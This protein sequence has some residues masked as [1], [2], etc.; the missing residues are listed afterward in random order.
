L[1]KFKRGDLDLNNN[2][3]MALRAQKIGNFLGLK[4]PIFSISLSDLNLISNPQNKIR[5]KW[6]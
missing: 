6:P 3:K 2:K 5:K 4:L 1:G